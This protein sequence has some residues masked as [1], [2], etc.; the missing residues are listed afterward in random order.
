VVENYIPLT[1]K[2]SKIDTFR[3]YQLPEMH[4]TLTT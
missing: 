2:K 4:F 3:I 1:Q